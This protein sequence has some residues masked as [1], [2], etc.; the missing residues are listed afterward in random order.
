MNL[1]FKHFKRN[2]LAVSLATAVALCATAVSFAEDGQKHNLDISSQKAG[3]A[4]VALGEQVGAQVLFSSDMADAVNLAGISGSFTLAEAL[5]QMLKGTGLTY[6]FTSEST[7]VIEEDKAGSDSSADEKETE[8]EELVVTGSR[9]RNSKLVTPITVITQEDIKKRGFSSAED[10]IRSLPQNVSTMN[11]VRSVTQPVAG[12]GVRASGVQG[13]VFANLRG[14]SEGATLVLINGKRTAGSAGVSGNAFNIANIPAASIE[15]VEILTDSAAAVYG[16]DAIAGVINIITRKDYVGSSTSVRYENAV[17]GGNKYQLNEH[18]GYSWGTG[19]ITATLSR[20]EQQPIDARKTGFVTEDYRI[21]GFPLDSRSD[22]YSSP[23]NVDGFGSLPLGFD[24]TEDWTIADLSPANFEDARSSFI[25]VEYSSQTETDSV[26]IE[27]RQELSDGM[28]LFS[29]MRYTQ[30]DTVRIGRAPLFS[31]IVPASNPFNRLGVPVRV[32]YDLVNEPIDKT[33]SFSMNDQENIHIG[34]GVRFDLPF[35]DWRADVSGYYSTQTTNTSSSS[36]SVSNPLFAQN[37]NVFGNGSAPDTSFYDEL[38]RESTFN[39]IRKTR[40]KGIAIE[41]D[42]LITAWD[43]R[44]IRGSVSAEFRVD[45]ISQGDSRDFAA[46]QGGNPGDVSPGQEIFSLAGEL[47]IPVTDSL[48]VNLQ[49]R[50][51]EYTVKISGQIP[52]GTTTSIGSVGESNADELDGKSFKEFTPRVAASWTPTDEL[53]F[54]ATWGES[55]KAPNIN[56]LVVTEATN[57]FGMPFPASLILGFTDPL[58]PSGAP[59]DQDPLVTINSIGNP[60]LKSEIGTT[61]TFGVQWVPSFIEGLR[62]KVTYNN[63]EFENRIS[64]GIPTGISPFDVVNRPDLF[65]LHTTRDENG[66]LIAFNMV[67]TNLAVSNLEA[68]DYQF[69]YDWSTDLGD[70]SARLDG[71]YN[72]KSETQAIPDPISPVVDVRG[73]TALD[74]WKASASLSWAGDAYGADV[75]ANYTGSYTNTA[76]QDAHFTMTFDEPEPRVSHYITWDLTGYYKM[77]DGWT[78][79]AGA[80]NLF[81]RAFHL[82]PDNDGPWDTRRVDLRGRVMYME[83]QKDFDF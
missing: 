5:D 34:G 38:R 74:R 55:F 82:H 45:G 80:R 18:I 9:I 17:N 41:T 76:M 70:F 47:A 79:R 6:K 26:N 24:G 13:D 66:R 42:G 83:V 72:M 54:T 56:A 46:Q 8:V 28:E 63:T 73:E 2:R 19:N 75:I 77:D 36:I 43:D 69:S 49:G 23:G 12:S 22:R 35:S 31:G 59:L 44:E 29:S 33:A 1:Q 7:V 71:V 40:S 81:N 60:G 48:I 10:I 78:V 37:A 57:T 32:Q 14:L 53:T 30:R 58:A 21:Y 68:I 16:S 61:Y 67:T 27:F 25:P 51:D 39:S 4:L 15:R 64:S 50:Y 65:P 11:S 3:P 62:A 20:E 52:Q